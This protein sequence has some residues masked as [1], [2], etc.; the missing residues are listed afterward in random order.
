[1]HQYD[2]YYWIVVKRLVS[3][4]NLIDTK[5][6]SSVISFQHFDSIYNTYSYIAQHKV[7]SNILFPSN[8]II[9]TNS[10]TYQKEITKFHT[11]LDAFRHLRWMWAQTK[12]RWYF[13]KLMDD[14]QWYRK[15]VQ[16]FSLP[17]ML[18]KGTYFSNWLCAMLW[19]NARCDNS[20][21][22]IFDIISE[23]IFGEHLWIRHR[24][25]FQRFTITLLNWISKT[26]NILYRHTKVSF[27][28][29]Q[30]LPTKISNSVS[31]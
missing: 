11:S 10:V 3:E 18:L 29:Q 8:V 23:S 1:M 2:W 25:P 7:Y 5:R 21:C 19:L 22:N 27:A 15:K 24:I 12:L 9:H 17:I 26:S 16:Y 14:L 4:M 30:Q 20:S 13:E 6:L 31:W 28:C